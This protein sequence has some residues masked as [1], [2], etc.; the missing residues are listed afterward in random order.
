M[1]K[2]TTIQRIANAKVAHEN[3]MKKIVA[4]LN[5][6]EVENPTPADKKE[7]EFGIWLY[8]RENRLQEI[9]RVL[10]YTNLETLHTRWHIEYLRIYDIFF[11]G[12]S[13]KG[14]LSKMFNANNVED[15]LLDKAKL[16]YSEL[17][18]TSDE[19]LRALGSSQRRIEALKEEK[20]I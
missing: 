4:L 17:E 19:L 8:S 7:C 10:F 14:F 2:L 3:Q 18:T 11:K 6:K 1:D 12:K 16:Y 20:F 13:K 15:M 5:G 9:L